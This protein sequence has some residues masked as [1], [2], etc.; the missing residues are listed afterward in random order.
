MD[1][2]K[3]QRLEAKGW[4][5]GSVDDFL[6]LSPEESALIEIRV[7]LASLLK[8][9]RKQT[10]LTQATLALHVRSSQARIARMEHADPSVSIDLMVQ[11]LIKMGVTRQELGHLIADWR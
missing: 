8:Q 7:A 11:T 9:K 3:K 2:A 1:E 4:K 5:V 6:S 10:Q